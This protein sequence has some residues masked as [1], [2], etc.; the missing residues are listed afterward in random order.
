MSYIKLTNGAPTAYTIGELRRDNPQV[1][2]PRN[3]PSDTLAEYAVH[4]LTVTPE[5][6]VDTDTQM[7]E[8]NGFIYNDSEQRWETA[9]LVRPKNTDELESDRAAIRQQVADRRYQAE[10]SGTIINGMPIDTGRDSQALITGAAVSAMLDPG[11]TVHWKTGDGFVELTAEQ[12]IG[13]ATAVRSHVQACFDREAE[14]LTALDGGTLTPEM[15][16]EGWPNESVP[17]PA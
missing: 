2:F 3:V 12:I 11:Y 14:L 6:E 15:L 13:V 5:P 7:L 10:T 17:E 4:P 8:R 16:Q 1:S 9:W